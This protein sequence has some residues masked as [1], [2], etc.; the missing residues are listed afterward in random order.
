MTDQSP[1]NVV[2][3]T[4]ARL[5]LHE[6]LRQPRPI[7]IDGAMGTLLVERTGARVSDC[8]EALNLSHAE[9]VEQIHGDYL[10]AGAE[11][12]ETNS[13]GA[14]RVKLG[15]HGL[16]DRVA[17]INQAA[18]EIARHAIENAGRAHDAYVAGSVGPLGIGIAPYGMLS[19]AEARTAFAEQ[20]GALLIAGVDALFFET[21]ANDD[22]LLLAVEVAQQQLSD[23]DL[24]LPI[25]AHATFN[26]DGTTY[27]GHSPAR[28]A[29]A[30][31][32]A[33]VT[34]LG[35]NCGGGP[36]HISELL[37]AMQRAVP[38]A[39]LSAMPNAG[40]PQT[41]GGRVMYPAQADY[42]AQTASTLK[43]IGARLVGGCCGTSPEHIAAMRAALDAPTPV[44]TLP[45][46]LAVDEDESP[47]SQLHPTELAQRLKAGL[48][49]ITV[50]MAPPRSYAAEKLLESARLLRDAGADILDVADTP[51][52]RMKMSAWAVSHLLQSQV[53]VETVLHFPT[54]GRN[55][56]RVQGDLLAAHALGLRNLFITMGDPARIGD[57]PDANDN[58]DIAPSRLIEVVK[59]EMNRGR[60]MG[61]ASIGRPTAFTVG[62]ALNMGADDLDRELKV[63]GKKLEAGAD[64]ALGQPVFEP[65]KID[66]FLEGYQ[67]V[68]GEPFSLPVLM[69]VMPLYSLKH[70]LFLHN[71]VPA[72]TI[73]D[74]I[75][76][77][78]EDAGENAPHVGV[79][80]AIELMARMRD[81][82]QGAYVIPAF[83]RYKLAAEVVAAIVGS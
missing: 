14:N 34:V 16:G 63:L 75:L 20:I 71:E 53:G 44:I 76:Q 25:I 26:R 80:I 4:V 67:R 66:R 29:S 52:A 21:F 82:V 30:L 50:E 59:H 17:A 54:R 70:A 11:L 83:G 74:G 36:A 7:L 56:L 35:A 40:Y 33:G 22:E 55:I 64:F 62:C 57:Y 19:Q 81:R 3:Q 78:L 51:A 24:D 8:L 18:V 58:F 28:V 49:T 73:P 27:L 69:G 5:S 47:V 46:T 9:R 32:K 6:R 23:R 42:F 41:V 37:T 48:F 72:F 2:P 13:F 60:D 77:R 12:I 38:D 1:S 10:E 43:A 65:E 31:H 61:G 79:Q 45:G 68:F 15:E 39:M